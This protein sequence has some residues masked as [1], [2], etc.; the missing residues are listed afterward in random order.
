MPKTKAIKELGYGEARN[1]AVSSAFGDGG[2]HDHKLPVGV[3]KK[4]N[5]N[6]KPMHFCSLHHHTTLSYLDGY[7]L[8]EAHVR[9]AEELLMPA[10]AFTEH[11][12]ISSHVK[13]EVAA[14]KHGIKPIFGCEI[15]MGKVGDEATQKKY[16][17][18]VLAKT[19]EGYRNLMQLVSSSY[20]EGF[21][22]EPT[23]SWEMLLRYRKGL[24]ILSG[25]QG[26]LLFCSTVGGKLIEESDASYKRGLEVA[27]RFRRAFGDNYLIEV[28]AFPELSKTRAFN[29]LAE[30]MARRLG[31]R[32]VG[33]MDCHYTAPDE[34]EIQKVLHNVRPGEKRTLEELE[35]AWGYE[36]PLCPP[37]NDKSIFRRLR[38][39]GLS[40]EAALQAIIST[41][42]IAQEINCTL[43]KLPMLR[44]PLPHGYDSAKDLLMD[45]LRDGWRYRHCHRMPSTQQTQYRE[46]MFY[47]LG[48]MEQKDFL[49][50]FLL[51]SDGVRYAKDQGIPV[52]P[53]RGSAAASLV[54]WLLRITEVNPML[55]PNLVFER[56]IDISRADLPDI[57]LDFPGWARPI[58][59]DYHVAKYGEKCVGNIGTFTNY[60]ARLALDDVGKVHHVP[61]HAVETLKELLVERS[62]G[63]LRASA[64]IEDTVAHFEA[65]A[66][67][68]EDYPAL[69]KAMDLEGNIKT[70]GVHAAGLVV[71]NGDIR[72]VCALYERVMDKGT[73][74]ERTIQVVSMDKYDAERH[75]H[76][77]IGSHRYE[78]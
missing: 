3:R 9:R 43:P 26:S 4:T 52:G 33:T 29:P 6:L 28:Q 13:A 50:Y 21:Y 17:L 22:Y 7:G 67:V 41:E 44:Y 55:F 11:G 57:D 77:G 75:D 48:I 64:T 20:A 62:S 51:V 74:N 2:T 53:A 5:G 14:E 34:A 49:D 30:R 61:K 1:A 60:K 25:C 63:D 66:K 23:V 35:Q 72:E 32:L 39:T 40:R 18:T 71:A 16:H 78:S 46:R 59:R 19:Q 37:P 38:D 24:V 8:P 56:F 65:A 45:W 54:C 10:I 58:V 12:N 70:F 27:R 69:R 42:E 31:I 73:A 15:Y 47:E 36:V 68:V 76:G